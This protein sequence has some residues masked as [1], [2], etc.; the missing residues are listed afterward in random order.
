LLWATVEIIDMDCVRG[1]KSPGLCG[2]RMMGGPSCQLCFRNYWSQAYVTGKCKKG[3]LVNS[4]SPFNQASIIRRTKLAF[5]KIS[6][7]ACYGTVCSYY[8]VYNAD[9]RLSTGTVQHYT[10]PGGVLWCT[11]TDWWVQQSVS[12]YVVSTYH[13]CTVCTYYVLVYKWSRNSI[14]IPDAMCC[15]QVSLKGLICLVVPGM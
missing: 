2:M 12:K 10:V 11:S 1:D 6:R 15:Y 7:W 4:I 9:C 5:D 14:A 3:H 8:T 13:T